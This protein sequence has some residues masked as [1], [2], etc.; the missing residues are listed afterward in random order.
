MHKILPAFIGF[1]YDTVGVGDFYRSP[2]YDKLHN[3][4]KGIY[5]YALETVEAAIKANFLGMGA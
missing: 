4:D 3:F 2:T 5:K 1:A